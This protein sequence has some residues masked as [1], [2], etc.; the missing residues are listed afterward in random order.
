MFPIAV[1]TTGAWKRLSN[2]AGHPGHGNLTDQKDCG[3]SGR[4]GSGRRLFGFGEE[5]VGAIVLE[6]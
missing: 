4:R 1:T 2:A 6:G 5:P 3:H